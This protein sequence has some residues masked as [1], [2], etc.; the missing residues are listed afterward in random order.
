M[1][2]VA[3]QV[4]EE[5]MEGQDE[6]LGQNEIDIMG[7]DKEFCFFNQVLVFLADLSQSFY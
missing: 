5:F 7:S 3:R 4:A 6:I 1:S 2:S